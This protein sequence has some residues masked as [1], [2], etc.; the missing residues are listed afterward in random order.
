VIRTALSVVYPKLRVVDFDL[1]IVVDLRID[2]DARETSVAPGVGI[3]GTDPDQPVNPAFGLQIAIG[4]LALDQDR[5]RLDSGLLA[6]MMG[7]QLDLE[8][9]ALGPARVHAQEHLRPVLALGP[10]GP[11][12]DLDIGIVG[13]GLSGE[14][15]RDLVAVRFLGERR[16]ALDRI[17][18]ERLVAF[19]LGKLHQLER[20][21][22]LLLDL[23]RR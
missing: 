21:G 8:P 18:D 1:D 23:G 3:I 11:G 17:D 14:Q 7:D 22:K 16:K 5:R 20:I 4:I 6:R 13:I 9:V 12:I 2:P 10:A 15:R 19:G